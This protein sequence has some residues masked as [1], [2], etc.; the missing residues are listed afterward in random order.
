MGRLLGL[1]LGCALIGAV[2]VGA[3]DSV[4]GLAPHLSP[5][6]LAKWLADLKGPFRGK[7]AEQLELDYQA[8]VQPQTFRD[9]Q[10]IYDP[11]NADKVQVVYPSFT[12][13]GN[14]PSPDLGF[15]LHV[16]KRLVLELPSGGQ[17]VIDVNEHW[18][19]NRRDHGLYLPDEI[20]I[21]TRV[22]D[23]QR[24]VPGSER[25]YFFDSI[26]LAWDEANQISIHRRT[27]FIRRDSQIN[28][29]K[30]MRVAVSAPISCMA[31]HDSGSTLPEKFLQKGERINRESVVQDSFFTKPFDQMFGYQEY[32]AHLKEN[33]VSADFV[34]RVKRDLADPKIA[35]AVPGLFAGLEKGISAFAWLDEDQELTKNAFQK[36]NS[37]GVY[38]RNGIWYLDAIEEIFEGKYRYWNP[39]TAVPRGL[40]TSV[41]A[42]NQQKEHCAKYLCPLPTSPLRGGGEV[43]NFTKNS[44]GTHAPAPHR[45]P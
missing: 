7:D 26:R 42:E 36:E 20:R 45:R 41:T 19:E 10:A 5:G 34:E 38:K 39:T 2:A 18:A 32:V 8:F 29:I 17:K 4:G 12:A 22:I 27:R 44:S 24:Y 9:L 23:G 21:K 15:G 13:E 31:C 6:A 1:V 43:S 37:Q 11:K 14:T 35:F 30:K 40:V 25:Q 16:V 33:N 3:T 28:K